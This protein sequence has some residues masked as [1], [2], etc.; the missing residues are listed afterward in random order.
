MLTGA[1]AG[2]NVQQESPAGSPVAYGSSRSIAVSPLGILTYL[3]Q[4]ST[5]VTTQFHN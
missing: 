3:F 1:R 4:K 5:L 2:V